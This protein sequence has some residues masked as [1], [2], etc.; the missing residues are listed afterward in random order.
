MLFAVEEAACGLF[1][2]AVH[3]AE[4]GGVSVAMR[5]SGGEFW[6]EGIRG[7]FAGSVTGSIFELVPFPAGPWDVADDAGD[8]RPRL[9]LL[10]H[11]ALVGRR[12]EEF[13]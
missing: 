6:A 7:I 5:N 1:A 12:L 2:E 9:V 8:G 11:E 10:S 4:V 3:A 13:F